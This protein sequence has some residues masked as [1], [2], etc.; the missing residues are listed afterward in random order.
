MMMSKTK[1]KRVEREAKLFG[2]QVGRQAQ[3]ARLHGV[4]V[5]HEHEELSTCENCGSS[6]F[7][8][9]YKTGSVNCYNC[10]T[11]LTQ[12]TAGAKHPMVEGTPFP[13]TCGDRANRLRVEQGAAEGIEAYAARQRRDRKEIAARK[14]QQLS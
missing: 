10:S 12:A 7:V 13:A 4:T 2:E 1:Q 6:A 3:F 9:H 5:F 11:L 8:V 14:K